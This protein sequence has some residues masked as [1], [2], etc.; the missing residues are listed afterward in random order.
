[1]FPAIVDTV[2]FALR[3]R[4]PNPDKATDPST[5][6]TSSIYNVGEPWYRTGVEAT[7][8]ERWL[9]YDALLQVTLGNHQ[10]L[11]EEPCARRLRR[12]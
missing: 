4:Q 6:L 9:R 2:M 5:G 3:Y 10:R 11:G 7:A 12:P 1:M 8:D